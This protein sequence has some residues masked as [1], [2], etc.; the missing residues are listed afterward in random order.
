[1]K[2]QLHAIL[3]AGDQEYEDEKMNEKQQ[4][5]NFCGIREKRIIHSAW[6]WGE[7]TDSPLKEMRFNLGLKKNRISV[8]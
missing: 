7:C 2:H 3:F 6:E 8:E 5:E 4:C 1:M